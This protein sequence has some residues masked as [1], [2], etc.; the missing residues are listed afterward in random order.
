[1]CFD[2]ISDGEGECWQ[3][4]KCEIVKLRN[5]NYKSTKM[6]CCD[7]ISDVIQQEWSRNFEIWYLVK[8][9]DRISKTIYNRSSTFENVKMPE[10]QFVFCLVNVE[11]PLNQRLLISAML[12]SSQAADKQ[13][14]ANIRENG[15]FLYKILL[16]KTQ[17]QV[18]VLW[19]IDRLP[20]LNTKRPVTYSQMGKPK[21]PLQLIKNTLSSSRLC[22]QATVYSVCG[23][24]YVLSTT[25][26]INWSRAQ[27]GSQRGGGQDNSWPVLL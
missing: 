22:S 25:R 14:E 11:G 19:Y 13:K 27:S 5:W 9:Y 4:S 24:Y 16:K 6:R 26:Y 17:F 20:G 8:N 3:I 15:Y 1:M 21:M 18:S 2:T 12:R 10:S 23:K 7:C